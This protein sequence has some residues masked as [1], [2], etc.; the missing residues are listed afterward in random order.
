MTLEITDQRQTAKW[1]NSLKPSVKDMLCRT[2]GYIL[3]HENNP[4]VLADFTEQGVAWGCQ[5][6]SITGV[7]EKFIQRFYQN[8]DHIKTLYDN[9]P[10]KRMVYWTIADEKWNSNIEHPYCAFKYATIRAYDKQKMKDKIHHERTDWSD[11]GWAYYVPHKHQQ[12]I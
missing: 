4:K 8:L 7:S 3:R 12:E 2:Y 11:G 1:F 10:T 6:T 5:G 9:Q